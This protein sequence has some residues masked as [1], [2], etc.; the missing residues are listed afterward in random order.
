MLTVKTRVRFS[1]SPPNLLIMNEL[2]DKLLSRILKN[3]ETGCWN[4][5]GATRSGYGAI[6]SKGKLYDTHRLSFTIFKGEIPEGTM[7]CHTCDNPKCVNPDHLFN[8]TRADNMRDCF[9]KGRMTVPKGTPFQAGQDPG[10]RSIDLETVKEIKKFIKKGTI[11]L[12]E[13][14]SLYNV[15]YDVV[16]GISCG[17][18]YSN[19]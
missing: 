1:P 19:V 14:S 10:N 7:V 16:R 12:K 11:T 8:G 13:L 17:R 9:K 15:S 2:K 6:K 3:E 18:A 4:W 5:Q